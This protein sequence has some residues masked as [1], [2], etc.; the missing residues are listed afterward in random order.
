MP[1]SVTVPIGKC[2]FTV[3]VV[4]VDDREVVVL[5]QRDDGLVAAVDVHELR[6]GIVRREL[7]QA[8][9]FHDAGERPRRWW[10]ADL[11]DGEI[12]RRIAI[13]RLRQTARHAATRLALVF[14][15]LRAVVRAAHAEVFAPFVLDDDG[16]VAAVGADLDRIGLSA[17]F[18]LAND[19][20]RREID[21]HKFAAGVGIRFAGVRGD[22]RITVAEHVHRRRTVVD[23]VA[24]HRIERDDAERLRLSRIGDVDQADR[25]ANAIGVDKRPA[26]RG[27]GDDLGD[28]FG[29]G[30]GAV[31][32][33]VG[34]R[35]HA[36]KVLL[37]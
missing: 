20:A 35:P 7:R 9:E 1:C 10:A 13:R 14:A 4:E 6:F 24:R 33:I 34:E 5:L 22:Q 21:D 19:A 18:D 28:R 12:A 8:G 25:A 2:F 30:V 15:R 3:S 31:V 16:G 11:Q 26:I 17:Q 32:A 36:L 29:G 23:I 27:R 37:A